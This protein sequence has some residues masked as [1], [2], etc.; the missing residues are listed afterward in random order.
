MQRNIYV[1]LMLVLAI[2]LAA[3]GA[4]GGAGKTDASGSRTAALPPLPDLTQGFTAKDVQVVI[5]HSK[6]VQEDLGKLRQELKSVPADK[7]EAHAAEYAEFLEASENL[8]MRLEM[9]TDEIMNTV[10]ETALPNNN[11]DQI[12]P[13]TPSRERAVQKSDPVISDQMTEEQMKNVRAVAKRTKDYAAFAKY[14]R[15]KMATW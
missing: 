15:E 6:A 10:T 5:Q 11:P 7:R 2:S 1:L 9:S 12:N 14:Y 13:A 4:G 8:Q 3:C